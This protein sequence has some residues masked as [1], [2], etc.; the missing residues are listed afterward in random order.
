MSKAARHFSNCTG[1]GGEFVCSLCKKLH[2]HC[3]DAWLV[4]DDELDSYWSP[5]EACAE[6]AHR[7]EL[8]E[9]KRLDE[10]EGRVDCLDCWSPEC[11]CW[12]CNEQRNGERSRL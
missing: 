5:L 10:E 11:V 4:S 1:C 2:G 9:R 7:E 8:G 12:E 3:F 6:C